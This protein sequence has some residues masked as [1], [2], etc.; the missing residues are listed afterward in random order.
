L[1]TIVSGEGFTSDTSALGSGGGK[2]TLFP[3]TVPNLVT[4]LPMQTREAQ[5]RM[6]EM[7]QLIGKRFEGESTPRS[8]AGTLP[9][10]PAPRTADSFS[11]D[12]IARTLQDIVSEADQQLTRAA[13]NH[14]TMQ[15]D[16]KL[17]VSDFKEVG[18]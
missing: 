6:N 7:R 15:D 11:A 14:E 2:F 12:E 8:R 10:S 18:G 3:E 1:E 13:S 4:I 5:E 9:G 17:L 16:L